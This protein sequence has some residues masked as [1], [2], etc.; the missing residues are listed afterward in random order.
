MGALPFPESAEVQDR[1][2][3]VLA[4]VGASAWP[5]GQ[6]ATEVGER[7]DYKGMCELTAADHLVGKQNRVLV[8]GTDRYNVVAATPWNVWPHIEL[9]LRRVSNDG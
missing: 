4:T 5:V 3:T 2:G 8:I 7:Y 9:E 1:A 6:D